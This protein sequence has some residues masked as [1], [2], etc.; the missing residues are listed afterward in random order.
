MFFNDGEYN[1]TEAN[2][3]DK[4]QIEV[5][6][7]KVMGK[8]KPD[9]NWN[10]AQELMRREH[11]LFNRIDWRGGQTSS[12]SFGQGYY[13]TRQVVERMKLLDA[14]SLHRCCVNCLSFNRTG[15]LIC[16]GSDDLCIIIW[17]WAKG[18]PRHNF[19]SGHSL[20]IFQTKFIDSVGCLDIVS[21]SRDGQVRRAVIPPSGSSSTKTTR[22]YNH[23]DA[24]HKLV[25]VPQSRHEIMSAGEDAAVKHFDLRSNACSTML[26]CISSEDNRRVRLFSI[27][28]HPYMPE[29]CVSG[30]DDKLRVYDKRNLNSKPV[31]EMTPKDLKDIKITQI[32]CAVYNHSGSEILASYSDAGIYLYDS[33]N[34][35]DGEYLHYY[36]GHINSRTIKGVNFFGPHSE[37]IISGSD[38]GNI[39]FWDKNTEAVMNFVKG[40]H[41]G[42]VNCLEQHPWMPVLATS[43]LDH[44]VKIWTPSGQPEAEVP[45]MDA[46]K[47]TLQRN[48]RR[49]ILDVGDFD[50]NQ[51]HYF[52]RQLIEPRRN[53]AAAAA[54]QNPR[55]RNHNL[56]SSSSSSSSS[57]SNISLSPGNVATG[58]GQQQEQQQQQQRRRGSQPSSSDEGN[59]DVLGC[60]SQ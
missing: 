58:T 44:N 36:E 16:S 47:E 43:G 38:C 11:N 41:A 34:Y 24:V 45:R 23:S 5:A 29:F 17:D 12:L 40:D 27:A 37:Y 39:F 13:A 55:E 57:S 60:R 28:H 9:Y 46:L 59:A 4:A 32:T 8:P 19:R 31:H 49:S 54:G 48:F 2:P 10:F 30:S 33:R 3:A 26:R 21:S 53:A 52:I 6:V 22:L 1:E 56:F 25:V 14:L 51:I 7:N 15:D 35:K 42:V 20:N 50:I 18:K